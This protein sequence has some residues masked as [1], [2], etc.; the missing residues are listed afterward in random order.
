MDGKPK[1]APFWGSGKSAA[2]TMTAPHSVGKS[3][4]RGRKRMEKS[5]PTKRIG[6]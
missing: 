5:D 2:K 6:L 4:S 3:E 1:I